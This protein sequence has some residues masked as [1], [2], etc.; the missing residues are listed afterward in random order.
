METNDEEFLLLRE[1]FL[2]K[3]PE[4]PCKQYPRFNL[5]DMNEAE[6]LAELRFA[7]HDIPHLAEVLQIPEVVTCYQGTVSSGKEA[8]CILLKRVVYPCR[9]SSMMWRFGRS[10]F[11][12]CL[13]ITLLMFD[14][15]LEQKQLD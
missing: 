7:K 3:N 12:L 15:S 1:E 11:A 8:L 14:W 9:Y 4:F 5:D 10:L 2:S 13:L 6:C